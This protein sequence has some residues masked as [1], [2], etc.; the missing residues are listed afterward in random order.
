MKRF[1]ADKARDAYKV[2]VNTNALSLKEL[3]DI[4]QMHP[5]QFNYADIDKVRLYLT[6]KLEA[7]IQTMTLAV[8]PT[9]RADFD[10]DL[11]VPP[12]PSVPHSTVVHQIVLPRQPVVMPP[13]HEPPQP[14]RPKPVGRLVGTKEVVI[15][16]VPV[17]QPRPE[18]KPEPGEVPD[19]QSG[20]IKESGFIAGE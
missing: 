9:V 12:A 5:A 15:A 7:A 19:K 4:V 1:P 17:F 14:T 10:F 16:E 20:Y 2:R 18:Y 11:E 3:V 8:A 6:Q 13:R